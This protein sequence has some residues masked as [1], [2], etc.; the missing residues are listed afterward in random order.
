[1]LSRISVN[2][3]LKANPTIAKRKA[4]GKVDIYSGSKV[5]LPGKK[6]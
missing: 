3:L 4:A 6:K 5:R 1:M 2:A